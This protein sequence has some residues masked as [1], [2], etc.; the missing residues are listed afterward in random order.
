[1]GGRLWFQLYAVRDREFREKLVAR[2][3]ASGYEAMLVTVDL[4]VSGKRER[5]PRNG[6]VTPYQAELANS[7]TCSSSGV[8]ARNPAPRPA[9][10]ATRTATIRSGATRLHHAAGQP[11]RDR[12]AAR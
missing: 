10:M 8:A 4:P 5:D 12:G 6:F 3:N 9:G 2:A 1:V 11:N 7:R